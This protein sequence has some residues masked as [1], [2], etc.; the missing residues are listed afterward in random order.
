L[1]GY[2]SSRTTKKYTDTLSERFR[3][4]IGYDIISMYIVIAIV[5]IN[6]IAQLT[7]VYTNMLSI[8]KL[9]YGH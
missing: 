4:L 3:I 6:A 5:E 9:N 7:C 2:T 8:I 1:L